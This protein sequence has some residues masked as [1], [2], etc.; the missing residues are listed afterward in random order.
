MRDVESVRKPSR[1]ENAAQRH[2][3]PVSP[4]APEAVVRLNR[5]L[6]APAIDLTCVGQ[7]IRSQPELKSLVTRMAAS[8]ALLPSESA[9]RLDDAIIMLGANRLRIVLYLWSLLRQKAAKI[10]SLN[11]R[12][13][14][15]PEALYLASFLRYL[16]MDSPDAAILHSE[17]FSFA[18]DPR[19]AE[20]AD[21]RDMLMCDF[22]AL[23]PALNPSL[24]K[25]APPKPS[26]P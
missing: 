21:L 4:D 7:E 26:K 10:S 23:I 1:K 13:G 14:W 18:L 6:D 12:E 5:L 11:A 22:L 9:H 24:L 25:S 17:M 2:A 8:L 20:F 19:R 15:S 16:G 3:V